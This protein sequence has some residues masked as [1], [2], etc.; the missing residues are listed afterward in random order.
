MNRRGNTLVGLMAAMAII[1]VLSVG[2]FYGS[3]MFKGG[4]QSPRKDGKGKTIPGLAKL[5]AQDTVCRSNLG[6]V[7]S[8]IQLAM[9]ASGEDTPP[10][11]IEETR[12]GSS[13]YECPIG[14]ERYVYDPATGQVGCPHPGHEKY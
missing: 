14:K 5:Q 8:A 7:R 3:G 10:Q 9:T 11:T 13:F 6:Q 2:A 1:A 4:A 12:I